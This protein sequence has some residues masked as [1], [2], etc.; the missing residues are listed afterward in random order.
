MAA[1]RDPVAVTALLDGPS[2]GG[3]TDLIA[4]ACA[5]DD[6]ERAAGVPSRGKETR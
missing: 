5:L 3:D 6:L 1:G 4:L 2:P